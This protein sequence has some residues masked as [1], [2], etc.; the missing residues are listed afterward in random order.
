MGGQKE[1]SEKI[2]QKKRVGKSHCNW[3]R[4]NNR[5]RT[6]R[7]PTK[8]VQVTNC[9]GKLECA[10]GLE[11]DGYTETERDRRVQRH[12]WAVLQTAQDPGKNKRQHKNHPK[13]CSQG[14]KPNLKFSGSF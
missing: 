1:P 10:K 4:N 9:P 13:N 5:G 7:Q 12:L 8:R 6:G 11:R 3:A 14:K 2:K